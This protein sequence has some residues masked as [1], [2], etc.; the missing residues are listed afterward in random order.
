[1]RLYHRINHRVRNSWS[2]ANLN[3]M[4]LDPTATSA[5]LPC[6][7]FS[8]ET[9]QTYTQQRI[10]NVYNHHHHDIH[11]RCFIAHTRVAAV[12]ISELR[13]RDYILSSTSQGPYIIIQFPP[14][15]R[16]PLTAPTRYIFDA[17]CY[18]LCYVSSPWIKNGNKNSVSTG[19]WGLGESKGKME[20]GSIA[21]VLCVGGSVNCCTCI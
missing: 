4:L 14:F 15:F 8:P 5:S 17:V 12:A 1:M 10:Y 11:H 19:L 7:F 6:I 20:G 2:D 3:D 13:Q 16:Y 9:N 21:R 18:I